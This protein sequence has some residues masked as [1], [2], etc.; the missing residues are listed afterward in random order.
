[1]TI[2]PAANRVI[3]LIEFSVQGMATASAANQ[4]NIYNI[5]T[6]GTTGGGA[7]T[8]SK[9][10]AGYGPASASTVSTTWSV[11]PTVGAIIVPLGCNANGGIYRWVARPDEVIIAIGGIASAL[12]WSV[13]PSVGTSTFTVTVVWAEDPF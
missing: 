3:Q 7:I 2:V 10:N 8:P 4:V 11:Q 1:M 6:A 12:G 5:T 9:L 13:R